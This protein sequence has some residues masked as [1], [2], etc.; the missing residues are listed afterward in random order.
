MGKPVA[1]GR[2]SLEQRQGQALRVPPRADRWRP[3]H[4]RYRQARSTFCGCHQDRM[5]Q[6]LEA[7]EGSTR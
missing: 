7:T 1:A 4:S 3:G 5:S 6:H 2:K